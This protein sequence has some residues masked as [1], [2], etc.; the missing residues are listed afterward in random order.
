M[1]D[2]LTANQR[3]ECMANIRGKNTAPEVFVQEVLRAM[4]HSFETHDPELPGKPD[5]ILNSRRKAIMVHGCFWHRHE[6]NAGQVFPKTRAEFWRNKLNAN[7][8]RDAR[9]LRDLRHLGFDVL[10]VWECQTKAKETA[11]LLARLEAFL[12]D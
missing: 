4:G 2:V 10:V 5:V 8:E 9:N 3:R 6:C 7:R 11:T 12:A 1:A